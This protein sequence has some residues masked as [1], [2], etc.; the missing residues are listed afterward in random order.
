MEPSKE[1]IE[2]FKKIYKK[3]YGKELDDKEAYESAYNLL[4]FFKLL[5][6]IDMKD[7][8]KS[9]VLKRSLTVFLSTGTIA[10]SFAT[11]QSTKR[12][13]GTIGMAPNV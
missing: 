13:A 4:N 10:A 3:E 12:P 5:M 9:V 1:A 6:D 7:R 11:P 8:Q 2:E